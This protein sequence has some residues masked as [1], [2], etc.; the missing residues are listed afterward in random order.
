MKKHSKQHLDHTNLY[1]PSR[2]LGATSSFSTLG[3]TSASSSTSSLNGKHNLYDKHRFAQQEHSD[4]EDTYLY[5]SA[6]ST[7][8]DTQVSLNCHKYVTLVSPLITQR[9]WCRLSTSTH[10]WVFVQ[11]H[12]NWYSIVTLYYTLHHTV[13]SILY[14]TEHMALIMKLPELPFHRDTTSDTI[15]SERAGSLGLAKCSP[16]F[17]DQNT[18]LYCQSLKYDW[19]WIARLKKQNVAPMSCNCKDVAAYHTNRLVQLITSLLIYASVR[20]DV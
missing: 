14:S 10:L 12:E 7:C 18:V 13:Y 16:I 6:T 11:L 17:I 3:I 8:I 5:T 2:L 1:Y 9:S 15:T 19:N 20:L 4:E